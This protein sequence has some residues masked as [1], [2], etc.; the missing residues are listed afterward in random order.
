MS[1]RPVTITATRCYLGQ[2]VVT[3]PDFCRDERLCGIIRA[4]GATARLLTGR[5]AF[6]PIVG[7]GL[8]S[9][10]VQSARPM[11]PS[12]LSLSDLSAALRQDGLTF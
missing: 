3:I 12:Q 8:A 7:T 5:I 10:Y 2:I 1:T 11:I 9:A 6:A 4:G